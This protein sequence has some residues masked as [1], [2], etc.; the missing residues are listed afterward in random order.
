MKLISTVYLNIDHVLNNLIG[1]E[2]KK[3]IGTALHGMPG[4]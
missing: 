4:E 3:S 2:R 1:C